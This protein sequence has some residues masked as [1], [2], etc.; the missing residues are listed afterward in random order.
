NDDSVYVV[1][2]R[3]KTV[4]PVSGNTGKA[5][6]ITQVAAYGTS[7]ILALDGTTGEVYWINYDFPWIKQD[8]D[9]YVTDPSDSD[10]Q[11]RTWKVEQVHAGMVGSH[12]GGSAK[13]TEDG[14]VTTFQQSNYV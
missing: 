10:Y 11:Y 8:G 13:T 2:Y 14:T 7:T 12:T 4:T 6:N 9:A 5:A 3:T 1:N